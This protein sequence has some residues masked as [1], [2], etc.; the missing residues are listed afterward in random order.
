MIEHL[1]DIDELVFLAVNQ[2]ISNV[3]FDWI[4]PILRNKYTWTPVYLFIII[5]SIRH[6]KLRGAAMILCLLITAGLS[7][8]I[9]ASVLKPTFKR[10]RPCNELTLKE[11]IVPRV[12]CGSGYSMPSSHASNH[13]AIAVFLSLV[14]RRSWKS[15][16]YLAYTWASLICLAQVY[17]GVHYPFDVLCGA[18]LGSIIGYMMAK[19][20]I[21][22]QPRISKHQVEIIR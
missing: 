14:F 7:D 11:E 9:S 10:I 4:M 21:K 17:V 12:N 5:F 1:K 22:W 2:G 3:A 13:F 6:F 20:F 16:S 8:F 18:V 15:I 19:L